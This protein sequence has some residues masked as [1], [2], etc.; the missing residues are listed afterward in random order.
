MNYIT[1]S[2]NHNKFTT[3]MYPNA[4]AQTCHFSIKNFETDNFK[5]EFKCNTPLNIK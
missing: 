1:C 5:Q 2:F 4:I 3:L